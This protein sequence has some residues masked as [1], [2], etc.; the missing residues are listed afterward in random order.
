VVDS[1]IDHL[2]PDI[3]ANVWINADEARQRDR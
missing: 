3:A 2:H 1:G